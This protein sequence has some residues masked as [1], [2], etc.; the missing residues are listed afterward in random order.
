MFSESVPACCPILS[1]TCSFQKCIW[2]IWRAKTMIPG[3]LGSKPIP[4]IKLVLVYNH[5][6]HQ[7]FRKNFHFIPWHS[8]SNAIQGARVSVKI[9][10]NE[11]SVWGSQGEKH[12]IISLWH[13]H[14]PLK[15]FVFLGTLTLMFVFGVSVS[16]IWNSSLGPSSSKISSWQ[17]RH[18][19][20]GLRESTQV[21][22]QELDETNM[23]F[24]ECINTT[25]YIYI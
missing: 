23:S 20:F 6:D 5:W 18:D 8:V 1:K 4:H 9:Q 3:F 2:C 15:A 13:Q 24:M 25:W 19:K 16:L 10:S 17:K 14:F 22:L 21:F 7:Q 12:R 11:G